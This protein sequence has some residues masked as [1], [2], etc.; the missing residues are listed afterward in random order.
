[1][2][3]ES[4]IPP[5]QKQRQRAIGQ[6]PPSYLQVL[7]LATAYAP[8]QPHHPQPKAP[9][10]APIRLSA[11][12]GPCLCWRQRCAAS[13]GRPPST[14]Q[15]VARR[16]G[17]RPRIRPRIAGVAG[18]G[19]QL[20]RRHPLGV[21][22]GGAEEPPRGG[23]GGRGGGIWSPQGAKGGQRSGARRSGCRGG[24]ERGL[25]Q[26]ASRSIMAGPHTMSDGTPARHMQE[27]SQHQQS[28][29]HNDSSPHDPAAASI[30]SATQLVIQLHRL[31]I[32]QKEGDMHPWWDLSDFECGAAWLVRA[33]FRSSATRLR[34][35][36]NR[37][38]LP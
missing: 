37:V 2:S 13:L 25:G 8:S 7:W 33:E 19:G 24:M 17:G 30:P 32:P 3:A 4:A 36:V 12:S 11:S 34:I 31:S 26:L 20:R 14:A 38:R 9:A 5:S 23:N 35:L 10:G 22:R 28:S 18:G 21:L 15:P 29:S 27:T 16:E 6:L 1:M